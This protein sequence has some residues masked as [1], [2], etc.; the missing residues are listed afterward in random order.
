MGAWDLCPPPSPSVQFL[1]RSGT[2]SPSCNPALFWGR[3]AGALGEGGTGE[4]GCR[5]PG[6]A[7]GGTK[8]G[9]LGPVWEAPSPGRAVAGISLDMGQKA[10]A[11]VLLH[12]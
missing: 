2:C 1:G 9:G 12:W 7:G 11:Q 10:W 5:G 6:E 8:E 3:V 4:Q